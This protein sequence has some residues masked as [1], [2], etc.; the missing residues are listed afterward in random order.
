[1]DF[2]TLYAVI[3][4]FALFI[5][6]AV[7]FG[8]YFLSDRL[9]PNFMTN[10]AKYLLGSLALSF[11]CILVLRITTLTNATFIHSLKDE[12]TLIPR[13]IILIAALNFLNNTIK[14]VK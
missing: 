5:V 14:K 9:I 11:L 10:A 1:M 8:I 3:L 7:S 13:T 2:I 4:Y 12:L 6:T